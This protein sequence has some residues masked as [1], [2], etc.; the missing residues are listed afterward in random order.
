MDNTIHT[1][2]ELSFTVINAESGKGVPDAKF[3]LRNND[4]VIGSARSGPDGKAV[5]LNVTPGA[6]KV[7]QISFPKELRGLSIQ[8]DVRL[9][10]N[11]S[12][13]LGNENVGS[14]RVLNFPKRK[15]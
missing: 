13:K 9:E 8:H 4:Q 15:E 12:I 1:T 5:F 14:I 7:S 11:G 6:Y 3:E 10:E 2:R